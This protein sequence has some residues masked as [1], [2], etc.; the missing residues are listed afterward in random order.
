MDVELITEMWS[1]MRPH[2]AGDYERAADDFVT[3]MA[4][5]NVDL[6]ELLEFTSD[7]YIKEAL[8]EYVDHDHDEDE[9]IELFDDE[10]EH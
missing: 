10:M 9:G 5:N 3:V 6:T 7:R 8:R 4:E 1:A 2:F